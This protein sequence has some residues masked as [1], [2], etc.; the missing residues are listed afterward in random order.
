M[1]KTAPGAVGHRMEETACRFLERRGLQLIERNYRCRVGELDIVMQDK[2]TLVF[3]EVR[4][5]RQRRFGGAVESIDPHKQQRLLRAA[6]HYLQRH[7]AAGDRPCRFD[8][9]AL[10]GAAHAPR[11]E[12][13]VDALGT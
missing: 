6:E 3:V 8:V 10:Q 9:V 4:Y 5:R 7:P 13:L 12:W 2:D 1:S 11:I